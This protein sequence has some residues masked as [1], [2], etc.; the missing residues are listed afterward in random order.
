MPGQKAQFTLPDWIDALSIEYAVKLLL[1]YFT[2][3]TAPAASGGSSGINIPATGG[4]GAVT[5]TGTTAVTGNFYAIQVITDAVLASYTD[6]SG[7]GDS[8]VGTTLVAGTIL[9]GSFTAFTLTSGAV[10]AYKV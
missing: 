7:S 4:S 1:F 6:A 5:E 10:R 2:G 9:Y 8:L 3:G